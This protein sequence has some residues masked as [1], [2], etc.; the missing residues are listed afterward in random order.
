MTVSLLTGSVDPHYQM[1]LV[2]GLVSAGVRVEVVGNEAMASSAVAR[3]P[4]VVVHSIRGSQSPGA[5]LVRKATRVVAYY[6]RLLRYAISTSAPVFHIQWPNKFKFFDRTVLCVFYKLLGK[7]LV[8][9]AHNVNEGTRDG[10]DTWVN[11]L[12][13]S[14]MYRLVDHIIVH[15][16]RAKEALRRDFGVPGSKVSVI[17]FGINRIVPRTSLSRAEAKGRLGVTSNQKV[18]LFFGNVVPYKGLEYLLDA[19]SCLLSTDD[20]YRVVIAGRNALAPEYWVK[21]I[22]P[23]LADLSWAAQCHTSFIPDED[24]E[25]YFKAADVLALPY[26]AIFQS[27]VLFIA[28]AF[29]LPVVAADVGS[30]RSDVVEGATG[31]M[32]RPRDVDSLSNAL[33][34]F[35]AGDLFANQDETRRRI[36]DYAAEKYSWDEIGRK[37][38]AVYL[39]VS[40]SI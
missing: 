14:V 23:R 6:V 18:V 12:S 5:P 11:R 20:S 32:C 38:K 30:F 34:T 33:R 26:V 40:G 24:V 9:T 7:K 4:R 19:L 1:D 21:V 13:L 2:A 17:E 27:G 10:N 8:H 25:L 37:T 15:T 36:A 3:D 28:Y 16:S 39:S 35:F 29:G 22:E 31:Y